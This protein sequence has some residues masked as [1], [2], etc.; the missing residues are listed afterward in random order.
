MATH[1]WEDI[2]DLESAKLIFTD[3]G[4]ISRFFISSLS[5]HQSGI[6]V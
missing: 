6:K 4:N 5:G 3:N 1:A 2:T